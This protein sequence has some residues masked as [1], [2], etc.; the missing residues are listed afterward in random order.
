MQ[1]YI[2]QLTIPKTVK[3]TLRKNIITHKM[4]IKYTKRTYSK[5]ERMLAF[6]FQS[7]LY[8]IPIIFVSPIFKK[9]WLVEQSKI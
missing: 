1:N 9:Q 6:P 7:D 4:W 5:D 8:I 2:I 3:I